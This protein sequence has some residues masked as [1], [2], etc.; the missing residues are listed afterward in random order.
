M[1]K[2]LTHIQ[3]WAPFWVIVTL[4]HLF[5]FI[6]FSLAWGSYWIKISLSAATLAVLSRVISRRKA[7][8]GRWD[9]ETILWGFGAAAVL[10]SIFW[11]GNAFAPLFVPYAQKQISCVYSLGAGTPMW[12]MLVLSLFVTGPGEEFFWRG[13]VQSHL[14]DAFGPMKGCIT[15]AILYGSVHIWSFNFILIASACVVGAF[16]GFLYLRFGKLLPVIVSHSVWSALV[17][18]VFP[19]A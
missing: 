7:S 11:L 12:L 19:F 6:S 8:F 14:M 5:W 10:Y 4:A 3:R 2:S 18:V 16:W 13:F 17:F 15:G 9:K 1:R